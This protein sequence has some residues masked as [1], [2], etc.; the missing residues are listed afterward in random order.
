M[1]EN[2]V[3]PYSAMPETPRSIWMVFTAFILLGAYFAGLF[4]IRGAN[5]PWW[6]IK[7]GQVLWQHFAEHGFTFPEHDVFTYTGGAIEWVN[8]EWLS[9][10][11]FYGLFL[12]GGGEPGGLQLLI[13]FKSLMLAATYLLLALYMRRLGVDWALACAGSL[14]ALLSAQG[15]IFLRPPFFTY[16]F[17]PVFL[18]LIHRLQRTDKPFWLI[19]LLS[20]CEIIWVNLHGGAVIGIILTCFWF[21][22]ESWRWAWGRLSRDETVTPLVIRS[23]VVFALVTIASFI[24]PFTYDIHLLPFKVTGDAFLVANIGEM[25]P[26]DLQ[27]FPPFYWLLLA[28][29]F[30]PFMRWRRI[31]VYEG[32]MLVFFAHQ[33][34]NHQRHASLFALFAAPAVFAALAEGR[35]RLWDVLQRG[36]HSERLRD[37]ARAVFRLGADAALIAI[38]FSSMYGGIWRANAYSFGDYLSD[39]YVKEA[40]PAQAVNFILRHELPG[41]MFNHDNFAGY[42][43][44]RLAPEH[45][46]VF[47]DSRFDLWGSRFAKEKIAVFSVMP[48]PMGAYDMDG[49]WFQ[50]KDIYYRESLE[51]FA[52]S[53]AFM[54]RHPEFAD[55][56]ASGLPYWQWVL[57]KYNANFIIT[58]TNP[59]LYPIDRVLRQE[60]YGW[61]L[62]YDQHGY[63]IYLRDSAANRPLNQRFAEMFRERLEQEPVF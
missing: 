41:P 21:A 22:Q 63:A 12:L 50:F 30:I 2:H 38:V 57:E 1:N 9:H 54:Q 6:H 48:W 55:W 17:I 23:G 26:P 10:I 39:G 47:T 46:Q 20:L 15:A 51:P 24:N 34:L 40:Y 60:F 42:L 13:A 56:W 3:E 14:V 43:I 28:M 45:L 33:T 52:R 25:R 11:V 18:L 5:D 4:P 29:L 59:N 62:I 44:Y 61:F 27:G 31:G 7:T 8:H 32:L 16:F 58:Y 49:N 35:R 19:A 36:G 37:I 53:E